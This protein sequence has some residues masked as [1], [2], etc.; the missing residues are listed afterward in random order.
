MQTFKLNDIQT[1]LFLKY[2]NQLRI[3]V[4]FC[5]TNYLHLHKSPCAYMAKNCWRESLGGSKCIIHLKYV[6]HDGTRTD[7][8]LAHIYI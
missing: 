5:L 1:C 2:K 6:I 3:R 4:Y 8:T 7:E